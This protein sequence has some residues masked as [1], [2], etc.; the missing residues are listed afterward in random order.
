VEYAALGRSVI[1]SLAGHPAATL[2]AVHGS[3]SGGGF[4]LVLACDRILAS[5][6]AS[7]SH[8]GVQRGLVTGWGG[9]TVVPVVL[10]RWRARRALLEG[11]ELSAEA[12]EAAG[13]V[14]LVEGDPAA[15]AEDHAATLA[16]VHPSRLEVSRRLRSGRPIPPCGLAAT[17]AIID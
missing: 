3:C 1:S 14:R 7:L 6:T 16:G 5:A 17:R 2:A 13:V 12:L 9:T 8:P 10:G 15:A 4:D 11:E